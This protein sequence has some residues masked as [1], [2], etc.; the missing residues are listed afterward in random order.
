MEPSR[1]R[2]M[3]LS[4]DSAKCQGHGRCT[5]V[6]P[7]LFDVSDDG[8]GVVLVPDPGPEYDDE[9]KTAI[10]SCPEQAISSS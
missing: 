8:F 2:G 6:S 9:V 3:H 1:S 7:D 10:G 5:L 4:I